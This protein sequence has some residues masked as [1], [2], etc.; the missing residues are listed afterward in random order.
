MKKKHFRSK[1]I[2]LG[3]LVILGVL[4]GNSSCI[5]RDFVTALPTPAPTPVEST[6]PEAD[7]ALI[8]FYVQ[9]PQNS[10][11]DDPL[12][13]SILDEVTG[14]ALNAKRHVMQP[15]ATG[16][17]VLGIPFPVGMVVKY[18]YSRQSEILA[19]EHTTDGRAV[20]YR[21]VQV[22][23]PAELHDV[24]ARWNDTTTAARTGRISGIA[25]DLETGT[26]IP[27]VI[28][29][30]GGAQA[31]TAGDG[32]FLIEGLLP[33]THN[34]VGLHPNGRYQTFQQGARVVAEADTP[35][36]IQM[37]KALEVDV[38]FVVKVPD[39][40]LPVV[41]IRIAGN[42]LSLG[43]TFAD[44]SG[45]VNT[46]AENMPVLTQLSDGSY[47]LIL[48]L[49]VGADIQYK[50]T[51]GDG[52]WNTERSKDGG[53]VLRQF[54]VPAEAMVIEDQVESWTLENSGSITFDIT[55]PENT[56]PGESISI[57]FNPYGWTEPLPMWHLGGQRW[58]YILNN[59]LDMLHK[60]GYRYCR[61]GQCGH[62]DDIR[63]PGVFTSGQV[64]ETAED[65]Q[66]LPD[67]IAAWTWMETDIQHNEDL[68]NLPTPAA[69]EPA[70][71]AGI[72]LQD[73]F[74]PSWMHSMPAALGD[75]AELNANW[76][77]LT[78]SW[79][80]TRSA[81][82]V[83][84][85]VAG[86]D[87]NWFESTKMI[88]LA[89]EQ[90]LNV[91]LRPVPNF[92]APVADWWRN[93]SRDF[94]WWVSWFNRYESFALHH[95]ELA[96][97]NGVQ[98]LILGGDWMAP[99][100]P[101]GTLEDGSPSGVPLDAETRY[102]ELIAKIRQ[103]YTGKIG[104]AL[105]YPNDV[106]APPKFITE[107]DLL[108]ILWSAPLTE[109]ISPEFSDL[110]AKANRIMTVDIEALWL[111][112]QLEKD[113][114]DLLISVAY[115]AVAGAATGCL[116]DP[117]LGCIPPEA[118]NYPAPDFPLLELDLA[119]QARAYNAILTAASDEHWITGIVSQG[120]YPPTVLWDKST[121]IH[122][123]PAEDIVRAWFA[124]YQA[125]QP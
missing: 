18:R 1:T 21:M 23:A 96:E 8:T 34:L 3:I 65:P 29:T 99:A 37:Q 11:V 75:I 12:Y 74:H 103:R 42:L 94:S 125:A 13:I 119:V 15:T 61:A 104:W 32:S 76:V 85:P 63:T 70:F 81:P 123:K 20:R 98:T 36:T 41:P 39:D 73:R 64:V 2:A 90:G 106:L 82:P 54:I 72:E 58:A 110:H 59:P 16:E 97:Q 112:W 105:T 113:E 52:F 6:S 109:K 66:G 22:Q 108:Y 17:Y 68:T 25:S 35:T 116:P 45:G 92:P 46:I 47:G 117:D 40:T 4:L 77:F 86:Q 14:L 55:V 50:Y 102:L 100:L 7:L 30:A 67:Q 111:A 78:P 79:S 80:F 57:Q 122:G 28:I 5:L 44:L 60:L 53:L 33:G 48:R 51:L 95:A 84:E 107:V 114:K 38:T 91:A 24:I 71:I 19:E 115:P 120:Y 43:N 69:R 49:P 56:P 121:S 10:P 31:I 9:P 27:G 87:P 83:L 62:A 101:G 124:A 26:P 88:R 118:L 93:A 89:Q